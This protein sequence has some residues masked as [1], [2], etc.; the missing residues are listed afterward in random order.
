MH[1][2]LGVLL[3]WEIEVMLEKC[4]RQG[5]IQLNKLKTKRWDKVAKRRSPEHI[6]AQ[7]QGKERDSHT[8]QVCGSK[9]KVQG[10]HIIDVQFNGAPN[11]ENIITLCDSHHKNAHSGKIDIIKFQHRREIGE[12][13]EI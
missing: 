8:C 1:Q 6:K 5:K 7:V 11:V 4:Y 13:K 2:V 9:E 12:K 3:H 10:H